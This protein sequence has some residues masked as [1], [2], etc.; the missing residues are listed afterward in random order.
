MR[1]VTSSICKCRSPW[2]RVE[3][4]KVARRRMHRDS[5]EQQ[6]RKDAKWFAKVLNN[7][8]AKTQ[9]NAALTLSEPLC[10]FASL[11][12]SLCFQRLA[13]TPALSHRMGEGEPS[14]VLW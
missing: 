14:A 13:L 8:D 9:R 7:K 4:G 6:R 11:L 10:V 3:R 2:A 12:F 5:L 1:F